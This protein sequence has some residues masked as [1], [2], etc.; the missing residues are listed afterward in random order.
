MESSLQKRKAA[1]LELPLAYS[2]THT[3]LNK[4]MNLED[5]TSSKATLR[6]KLS[7][8]KN[9][10]SECSFEL[11]VAVLA[12]KELKPIAGECLTRLVMNTM[13]LVGACESKYA[14]MGSGEGGSATETEQS[15]DETPRDSVDQAEG[16]VRE[17]RTKK[18]KEKEKK[19]DK[20]DILRGMKVKREIEFGDQQL[21]RDLL[22]R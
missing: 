11:A 12:P 8:C 15:P 20:E 10:Y 3:Q 6:E 22:R 19:K 5:L 18:E 4:V 16:L 17:V 2:Q 21:L 1:A 7:E 13:A 9:V 14:L